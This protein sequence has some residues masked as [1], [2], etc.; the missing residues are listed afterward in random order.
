MTRDDVIDVLTV[1]AAGDRRTVGQADVDVWFAVIGDLDK[2]LALRAVRDHLRECPGVWL[3]PGH[4]YQRAR[5]IRRDQL[6]R[7]PDHAREARQRALEAKVA[8]GVAEIAAG[9]EIRFQRPSRLGGTS[10]L[11]V[12]CPWCGAGV[13][14]HCTVP[15]TNERPADGVHPSRIDAARD[16]EAVK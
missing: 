6:E 2:D 1:V 16:L 9:K 14:Q 8:E 10:P 5:A 4:V 3:E 13:G 7:E 15:R 11:R 12:R